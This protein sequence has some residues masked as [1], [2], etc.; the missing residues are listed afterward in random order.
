MVAGHHSSLD[1]ER[2]FLDA[3]GLTDR[4]AI[5]PALRRC[6]RNDPGPS[7]WIRDIST[8]LARGL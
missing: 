2:S 5:L 6:V 3:Y 8:D 7:R 4:T 1:D